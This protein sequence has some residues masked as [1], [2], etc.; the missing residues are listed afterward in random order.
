MTTA[1]TRPATCIRR[2]TRRRAFFDATTSKAPSPSPTRANRSSPSLIPSSLAGTVVR[3]L[4]VL[5]VPQDRRQRLAGPEQRGLCRALVD[6][7][8]PRHL[9]DVHVEV[10][11]KHRCLPLPPW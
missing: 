3:L 4:P 6:P 7:Q 9:P 11:P 5:F 10:I 8:D 2:T 1:T